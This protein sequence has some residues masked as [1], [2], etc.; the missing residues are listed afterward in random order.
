MQ[1]DGKNHETMAMKREILGVWPQGHQAQ[2]QA[3]IT[4]AQALHEPELYSQYGQVKDT[5]TEKTGGFDK[6]TGHLDPFNLNKVW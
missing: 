4:V 2:H 5:F 1:F 3:Q 6:W